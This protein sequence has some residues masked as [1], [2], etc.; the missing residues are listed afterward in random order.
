MKPLSNPGSGLLFLATKRVTGEVE[1]G[2]D[3]RE[4]ESEVFERR[5]ELIRPSPGVRPRFTRVWSWL[6]TMNSSLSLTLY[7]NGSVISQSIPECIAA[8]YVM[9]KA[10]TD[11][12]LQGKHI[13][14]VESSER[15]IES[16]NQNLYTEKQSDN[17][18]RMHRVSNVQESLR[19][20]DI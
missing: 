17:L 1:A 12:A 7:T 2:S 3:P 14:V 4:S 18:S 16:D 9:I 6:R 15:S 11:G 19:V 20:I 8:R 5:A 10:L 13:R